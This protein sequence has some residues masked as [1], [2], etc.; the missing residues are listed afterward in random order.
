MIMTLCKSCGKNPAV[1][2]DHVLC[3]VCHFK[4]NGIADQIEIMMI[5]EM[6]K[7][8]QG[9]IGKDTELI[10]QLE[11]LIPIANAQ[12]DRMRRTGKLLDFGMWI[13]EDE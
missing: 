1:C 4:N 7:L 6:G 2:A 13:S 10:T 11:K 5:E 3:P 8:F 9:A 12:I